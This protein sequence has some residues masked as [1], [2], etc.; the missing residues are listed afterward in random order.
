MYIQLCVRLVHDQLKVEFFVD[1][2]SREYWLL[3]L[4]VQSVLLFPFNHVWIHIYI[5][6]YGILKSC[7]PIFGIRNCFSLA[8][9]LSFFLWYIQTQGVPSSHI[10]YCFYMFSHQ[11]CASMEHTDWKTTNCLRN[12][13]DFDLV[14]SRIR[15]G[16]FRYNPMKF[17]FGCWQFD[18]G[19]INQKVRG[20]EKL[21]VPSEL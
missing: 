16:L 15:E 12:I 2:R 10:F 7:Y 14:F 9:E 4:L 5:H 8:L 11:L 20:L 21:G 17:T 13:A 3:G 6:S 1:E 18:V 19:S